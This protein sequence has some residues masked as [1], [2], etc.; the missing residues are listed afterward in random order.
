ME[1]MKLLLADDDTFLLDMYTAK[2]TEEGHTV[3]AA[4]SAE[5]ALNVLRGGETFD[6]IVF[7]MVMPGLSGL[8]LMKTIKAEKLGGP[9]LRCIVLSN[10][11][12]Q[13][14]ISTATEAGAA[15]YIV[16]AESIPSQVIAKVTQLVNEGVHV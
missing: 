9:A 3:V 6:A 12:E 4:K 7:D 16:K 1:G 14:D 13:S 10:Q 5:E 11:G 8:D 15:G 2:F